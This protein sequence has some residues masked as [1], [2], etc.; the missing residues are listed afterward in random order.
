[1]ILNNELG[2][3]NRPTRWKTTSIIDQTV[4]TPES[5]VSGSWILDG[6]LS[7]LLDHEV[8]V[9]DLMNL[10]EIVVGIGTSQ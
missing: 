3:V 7:T 6:E 1:M 8:I 2:K 9:C 4:T 5:G 10:D